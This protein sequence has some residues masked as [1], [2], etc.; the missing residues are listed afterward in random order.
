MP[1]ASGITSIRGKH[2]VDET[3]GKSQSNARLQKA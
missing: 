2:S 1:L 3:I